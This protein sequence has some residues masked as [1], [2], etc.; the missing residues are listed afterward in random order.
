MTNLIAVE[1]T[2]FGYGHRTPPRATLTIDTRVLLQDPHVDPAMRQLTGRHPRVRDHVLHTA[3]AARLV[4]NTT[5]LAAALLDDAGN[6]RGLLVTIA[7][8]CAGGRHRSVALVDAIAARLEATG[9]R[10]AVDHLDIARP[11]IAR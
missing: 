8:G 11:V 5:A 2:S 10:T 4:D 3:G 1:L 7:V 6:P 9:I